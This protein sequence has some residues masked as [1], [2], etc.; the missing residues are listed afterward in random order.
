MQQDTL[1]LGVRDLLPLLL[2]TASASEPIDPRDRE[3]LAL[4]AAWDRRMDREKAAPLIFYAWIR[5]LNRRL[6]ADELGPVFG[7]F[8]YPKADRLV[9][10]LTEGQAW[11]DDIG[12]A[13]REDCAGQV[14][15]ALDD[16][17]D[18]LAARFDRP[19]AE[20]RWGDA[21]RAPFSHPVLSRAPFFDELFGYGVETDGGNNTLN[22]GG[23]RASGPPETL[24]EDVHGP[25]YRAV[26]DLADLDRSRFMIAT[27]QSGN[28][29]SPHYG[30]LARRWRD[31]IYVI[32]DGNGT[33]GQAKL[34]LIPGTP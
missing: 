5:E 26:Y 18:L 30:D 13:A 11:C 9:R 14:A 12:S 8:Q 21:H 16:A 19:L 20:L 29:F 34:S 33:A 10:V 4:L 15:R 3:A 1:S 23:A 7:A 28:P 25:G 22:K 17:L 24:F 27:G 6:F 31:G 2:E 32:L